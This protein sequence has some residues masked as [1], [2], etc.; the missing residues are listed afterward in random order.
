MGLIEGWGTGIKLAMSQ[1]AKHNLP[2]ARIEMKGFF[3]QVSS[4]W[5]WPKEMKEEDVTIMR[6][7]SSKGKIASAEVAEM[8]QVSDRTA[9]TRLA[10]LVKRGL[11]KKVGST[12]SA[13]YVPA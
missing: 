11:L 10:A 9:R 2:P 5:A 12:R 4:V 3:T 1:L 13:V 7:V 6:A 8:F